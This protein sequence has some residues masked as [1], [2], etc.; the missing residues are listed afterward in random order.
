MWKSPIL[1]M[2][3][4]IT[5]VIYL[6]IMLQ[7]PF[8][9]DHKDQTESLQKQHVHITHLWSPFRVGNCVTPFCPYDQAQS[10]AL[11]SM[12]RAQANSQH[13]NLLV[14][15][16][17]VTMPD[18]LDIVPEGFETLEPFNRS[19]AT[20]YPNMTIKGKHRKIPF[21]QDILQ[22]LLAQGHNPAL[23]SDLIVYTNSDIILHEDFYLK[24]HQIYIEKGRDCF[25]INR[26]TIPKENTE[27]KKPYTAKDLDAINNLP[28][29]FRK[30]H[31][32]FDCF[33]FTW[34]AA[35]T[36]DL[37]DVYLGY[38]PIGSVVLTEMIR[39]AKDKHQQTAN[40]SKPFPFQLFASNETRATFH[41]GED[42]AWLGQEQKAFFDLNK[43]NGKAV[44][45]RY[46]NVLA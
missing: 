18:E 2:F 26:Q 15:L 29:Q 28:T 25:A 42:R 36:L 19:T 45:A 44:R 35:K 11:A 46:A 17:A 37:G 8:R 20:Q 16:A 24:I 40:T 6:Y 33:V 22:S 41:L 5:L 1:R 21:W 3:L 4:F 7:S 31:P 39:Y 30:N 14:K 13:A 23:R 10:V 12:K 32:G 43:E 38:P 34:E 27:T 9:W